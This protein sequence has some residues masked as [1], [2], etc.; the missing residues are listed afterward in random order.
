MFSV[1][2][3]IE[4]KTNDRDDSKSFA[5]MKKNFVDQQVVV[6]VIKLIGTLS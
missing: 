4:A 1:A 5:L 2:H 6:M 3:L